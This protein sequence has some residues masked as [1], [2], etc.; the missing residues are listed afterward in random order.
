MYDLGCVLDMPGKINRLVKQPVFILGLLMSS[1]LQLGVS[2][3]FH[4]AG[5]SPL[6]Y[7]TDV[8]SEVDDQADSQ[9]NSHINPDINPQ[10]D[11]FF[12]QHL[13]E[14]YPDIKVVYRDE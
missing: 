10:E 6:I 12:E 2:Q 7:F 11:R 4:S 9:N 8:S 3:S 5:N 1:L 13:S 14:Y